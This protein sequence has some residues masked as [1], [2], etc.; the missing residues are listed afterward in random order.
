M[1]EETVTEDQCGECSETIYYGDD[2][3]ACEWIDLAVEHEC[4]EEYL[5]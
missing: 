5:D 1:S 3:I 4:E 2:G